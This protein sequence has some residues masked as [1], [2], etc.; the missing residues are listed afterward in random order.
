[1]KKKLIIIISIVAF[2]IVAGAIGLIIG[3]G[4]NTPPGPDE[5]VVPPID[6]PGVD[7]SEL[8]VVETTKVVTYDGPSI[9]KSSE[10]ASVF[11]NDEE[12]FVY[13]TRVNH[14]RVFTFSDAKITKVPVVIFDFEGRVTV[15]VTLNNEEALENVKVTPAMYNITP[16]V[17]GNTVTFTLDYPTTYTL[18]YNNQ[19]DKVVHLITR[20]IETDAPDPEN[21]PEDVLYIGPGVYKADAIPI[22]SNKTVYIAGGALVYGQIRGGSV[23]NVKIIGRGIIS[24]EIYPRTVATEFTIPFE[25]QRSKNI[26]VDGITF[27]DSAGWTINAYFLDGFKMNDIAIITGRGNGDGISIQS[28][29]NVE[30]TNC[31]VRSWDDSLVVKNYNMGESENVL[32]NNITIW[33]DLAQSMEVGYEC[34]GATMKNIHFNNITVLHNFHKAVISIH[35]ADQAIID[36]VKFTNITVEDAHNDGD[37]PN[38]TYD[39]LFLDFQVLYNNEWTSSGQTRGKVKN[40]IVQNVLVLKALENINSKISGFD[41]TY[42]IDNVQLNNIKYNGKEVR[43]AQDLN[44]TTK[45]ATNISYNYT[46]EATGAQLVKPYRLDLKNVEIEHVSKENIVQFGFIVPEFAIKQIPESY[47]GVI[48]TGDFTASATHGSKNNWD[49]GTFNDTALE[50]VVDKDPTTSWEGPEWDATLT[51]DYV[52]VSINFDSNKTIGTVRL[53]GDPESGIYLTQSIALYGIKGSS[54]TGA[55][56]KITSQDVYEFSPATGNYV[57]IVI[58]PGEFKAIQI[59]IYHKEG[60]A[61]P[62]KAFINEVEFYP[63]SLTLNKVITGTTHEDVYRIENLIDGNRETYYESSKAQGF[64]TPPVIT[65]DLLADYDVK[66]INLYLVPKL[67]WEARTEVITISVSTDG[68]NYTDLFVKKE[69]LFDPAIGSVVEIILDQAVTARYIKF[70]VYS[71]T[72]PGNEGAQLSEITVYE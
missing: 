63:A 5:P 43:G 23:E 2:I 52:A 28:C 38:E 18:E 58:N 48:V 66:Y 37:N 25:F 46:S 31:F 3:L 9:I 55:Y 65:I 22:T 32:F 54:S 49:D 6:I 41:A 7:E 42:S 40:V 68:V 14:G 17:E 20:E 59:R 69:C 44:L 50:S 71:N 13:E 70:T 11:V 10:E 36:G 34:Y 15:K 35:N 56:S 62:E 67:T 57:D 47:M 29:K 27:L 39:N 16:T 1:M 64:T 4:S 19:T 72:A 45:Y 61:Y 21:L 8:R 60:T 24:G 33:T 53:Y 30:V 51:N 12:L 26:S